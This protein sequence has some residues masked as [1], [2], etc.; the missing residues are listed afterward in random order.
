MGVLEN[1]PS[2]RPK[3][4]KSIS[5]QL[6]N[7]I[8]NFN[9]DSA[10]IQNPTPDPGVFE[11]Q[12]TSSE[13]TD[14]GILIGELS[15]IY[16]SS[17]LPL[18]GKHSFTV[19]R[20]ID[21]PSWGPNRFNAKVDGGDKC[22]FNRYVYPA[23]LYILFCEKG[24]KTRCKLSLSVEKIQPQGR[25]DRKVTIEI[26]WNST[27]LKSLESKEALDDHFIRMYWAN[28]GQPFHIHGHETLSLVENGK[29]VQ[30]SDVE[31]PDTFD[32]LPCPQPEPSFNLK[33]YDYQLRTL[34]WMQ[35]VEDKESSLYYAPN[36]F[37][38]G[39]ERLVVESNE[40]SGTR[41]EIRSKFPSVCGGIIADKPGIGKT[42][43]TIALCHTRPYE[44]PEDAEDDYILFPYKGRFLSKATLIF[45]PSNICDQWEKEF[46]KCLGDSIRI[47]QIKGKLHY[48]KTT[49]DDIMNAEIII[50]S[51]NFLQNK[52]YVGCSEDERL[53]NFGDKKLTKAFVSS[54]DTAGEY[55][56]SWFHFNRIVYDEFHEISDR[57]EIIRDQI[58]LMSADKIWGLTG[59]PRIDTHAAVVEC[60]KFLNLKTR[61]EWWCFP[62]IESVRFIRNRIRRNEPDITYPDPIHETIMVSQTPAEFS[63]YRS[64]ASDANAVN[65]LML[66][67]HY[68]IMMSVE[69]V[70]GKHLL[71]IEDV[72]GKVQNS[73]ANSIQRLS[74]EIQRTIANIA[75]MQ[76]NILE[77]VGE[78]FERLTVQI[79]QA[80]NRLVEIQNKLQVTQGQFNY[81]QNFAGSYADGTNDTNCA[82]CLEDQIAKQDAG[83][84]PC[85]HAFC[86]DCAK[87]VVKATHECPTCRE[88]TNLTSIMKLS[89][90][91]EKFDDPVVKKYYKGVGRLD[92]NMFGSKIRELVNYIYT[93]AKSSRTARFIIFIQFGNLA[94]IVSEALHTYG[95]N[96]VRLV[97]GWRH[98]ESA[99]RR[100]RD[101]VI[102]E[103]TE[104][105]THEGKSKGKRKAEAVEGGPSKTIKTEEDKVAKPDDAVK[106]LILSA[107]DSVSGLNLTEASHCIILHPFHA[108]NEEHAMAAEVQGLARVL[109]HGQK[110]TVKIVRFVVQNTIEEEIHSRREQLRKAKS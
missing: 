84:F 87:E 55:A 54:K 36:I 19:S 49:I 75:Q 45:A 6:S 86:W 38:V 82:I 44:D 24:M 9:D 104:E 88:R 60:A 63:F 34:A 8:I 35:G 10:K 109:R 92:P 81:F 17:E 1:T 4:S 64:C 69:N 89:A 11:P 57:N 95:I 72:A 28:G 56:L 61:G 18:L 102:R 32:V 52:A 25:Y 83:V 105:A 99:L 30:V 27:D 106:V 74:T 103:E 71:S 90:P 51:Y 107:Q 20:R 59:T 37:P 108:D 67:N 5:F 39:E 85:G 91:V 78:N 66:C 110:K 68:Q 73:R 80:Q 15:L 41:D 96:N 29:R 100:F 65:L 16:P 58:V 40:E 3:L 98:R 94:K 101:S 33:L 23:P 43:T 77:C 70:T 22:Y 76:E 62:E 26:H 46:R 12:A 48:V 53:R 13:I 21:V 2:L 14:D 47:L 42:I 93:E 97:S 7:S 50:V 79:V 31:I